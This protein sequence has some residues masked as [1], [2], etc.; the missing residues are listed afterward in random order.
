MFPVENAV[1]PIVAVLIWRLSG[2]AT[3]SC[4]QVTQE[5]IW[6]GFG[7]LTWHQQC[8][9]QVKYKIVEVLLL[10][11]HFDCRSIHYQQKQQNQPGQFEGFLMGLEFGLPVSN[12]KQHHLV[13]RHPTDWV[14]GYI[15]RT[16]FRFPFR[17][18][19]EIPKPTNV[20]YTCCLGGWCFEV[21]GFAGYTL[22]ESNWY[23]CL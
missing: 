13:W 17:I 5:T 11:A 9:F 23:L 14:V 6:G 1:Q 3:T 18:W 20:W 7:F 15:K 22:W 21:H 4:Y 10:L 8:C 16:S 12:Q 2:F 19:V